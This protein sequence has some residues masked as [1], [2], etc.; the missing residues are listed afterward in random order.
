MFFAHVIVSLATCLVPSLLLLNFPTTFAMQEPDQPSTLQVNLNILKPGWEWNLPPDDEHTINIFKSE[1]YKHNDG[2]ATCATLAWQ[3]LPGDTEY[4]EYMY[5]SDLNVS[6]STKSRAIPTGFPTLNRDP[7]N[8]DLMCKDGMFVYKPSK[9][10]DREM[11]ILIPRNIQGKES[12]KKTLL[13]IFATTPH[14]TPPSFHPLFSA[15]A[16]GPIASYLP[17]HLI[18]H[19]ACVNTTFQ[20]WA[21]AYGEERL[22]KF[23]LEKCATPNTTYNPLFIMRICNPRSR[24]FILE[25]Q[26]VILNKYHFV[27]HTYTLPQY[28]KLST[29]FSNE[30]LC[31]AIQEIPSHNMHD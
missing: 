7:E 31:S 14:V 18:Y 24:L 15:D 3:A 25:Q 4:K 30:I 29:I 20:Q 19:L 23:V 2:R 21:P 6:S 27:K 5:L 11:R 8:A 28:T 10:F 13:G 9:T 1:V 22:K 26:C 12:L 16:T 17:I